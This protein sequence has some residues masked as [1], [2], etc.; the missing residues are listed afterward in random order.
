MFQLL[1]NSPSGRQQI[2]LIEDSG[3]YF[4]PSRVIW[5]ERTDGPLPE[6]TLGKM[7]R[8]GDQL[9]TLADFLPEHAAAVRKEMLPKSVPMA[10]A[11]VAMHN[12]GV[13]TDV[14]TFIKSAAMDIQIYYRTSPSIRRDSPIVEQVRV[15]MG[16][17]AEFLDD[18]FI[19]AENLRKNF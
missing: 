5:D 18:L 16:W 7:Q 15:G 4:D 1:V 19:A 13:L 17:T 3:A 8:E 6:I 2:E 11:Q 10:F 14:E 9:I 12:A